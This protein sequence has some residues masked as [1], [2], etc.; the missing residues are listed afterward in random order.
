MLLTEKRQIGPETPSEAELAYESRR[1]RYL[2]LVD[3]GLV[4]PKV[5]LDSNNQLLTGPIYSPCTNSQVANR[6][7]LNHCGILGDGDFITEG[8]SDWIIPLR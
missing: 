6:S 5:G 2:L 7:T 4:P 8:R 3:V 1:M